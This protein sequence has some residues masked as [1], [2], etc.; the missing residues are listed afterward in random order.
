MPYAE[1]VRGPTEKVCST[2]HN[3][4][5]SDYKKTVFLTKIR[6]REQQIAMN[7]R[8]S[9]PRADPV[10]ATRMRALTLARAKAHALT[11]TCSTWPVNPVTAQRV[12]AAQSAI[13]GPSDV[14]PSDAG[15]GKPKANV[16]R[17]KLLPPGYD[18]RV[19]DEDFDISVK[20]L[21]HSSI[22]HDPYMYNT[23]TSLSLSS[24]YKSKE[25]PYV[26]GVTV[27]KKDSNPLDVVLNKRE[28]MKGEIGVL[29][30]EIDRMRSAQRGN[31]GVVMEAGTGG[32]DK[33]RPGS[34][35][36]FV[37]TEAGED[38]AVTRRPVSGRSGR[39]ILTRASGGGSFKWS[40][41]YVSDNDV[42][43]KA[44]RDHVLYDKVKKDVRTGF[45]GY[46]EFT[47]EKDMTQV[48][49]LLRPN[50]RKAAAVL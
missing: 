19:G 5:F 3:E 41:N 40:D 22:L 30:G 4:R 44:P 47:K 45:K 11:N 35:L 32:E 25:K 24:V 20:C 50:L 33:F 17:K 43:Y 37:R 28:R 42:R 8:P 48:K 39:I 1:V 15:S 31:N 27:I 23:C 2:S 14:G 49:L 29:E 34:T 6:K 46:G 26:H 36:G 21:P 10:V 7:S 12:D 38:G 18:V 9:L 13:V 16:D